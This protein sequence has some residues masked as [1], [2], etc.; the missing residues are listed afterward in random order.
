LITPR[1]TIKNNQGYSLINLG[2][3]A[4]ALIPPPHDLPGNDLPAVATF[5]MEPLGLSHMVYVPSIRQL[6]YYCQ[7]PDEPRTDAAAWQGPHW[8]GWPLE[9]G[10]L[11][12]DPRLISIA[13]AF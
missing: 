1:R 2:Y 13:F 10:H 11:Y 12:H 6:L 9:N 3:V 5:S 4:L 7:T 8:P